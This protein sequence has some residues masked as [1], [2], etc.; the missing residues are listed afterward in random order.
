MIWRELTKNIMRDAHFF[1]SM[2]HGYKGLDFEF[3]GS[4]II[5]ILNKTKFHSHFSI[6]RAEAL[7][8]ISW[9]FSLV[10]SFYNHLLF[11]LNR[12]RSF[13]WVF[14]ANLNFLY[15]RKWL[16]LI[17][18]A[19][20]NRFEEDENYI[21]KACDD[22]NNNDGKHTELTWVFDNSV[23]THLLISHAVES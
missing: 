17:C 10:Q 16:G 22:S 12:T 3:F 4:F 13:V 2:H 23:N 18:L 11:N 14:F 7:E 1:H 9:K 6:S 19:L 8:A 15:H 21:W 20:S 5:F